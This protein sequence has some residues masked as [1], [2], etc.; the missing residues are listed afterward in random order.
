MRWIPACFFLVLIGFDVYSIAAF[1]AAGSF[2]QIVPYILAGIAAFLGAYLSVILM[3]FL[4][5]KIGFSGFSYYCWG[6]ALFV[7][8]LYLTIS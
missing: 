6:A 8:V 4:A 7:F 1:G 2:G 3:R 5:V